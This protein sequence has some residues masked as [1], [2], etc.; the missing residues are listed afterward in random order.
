MDRILESAKSKSQIFIYT[1][2][3]KSEMKKKLFLLLFIASGFFLYGQ[4]QVSFEYLKDRFGKLDINYYLETEFGKIPVNSNKDIEV[5]AAESEM[6]LVIEMSNLRMGYDRDSKLLKKPRD[7]ENFFMQILK[8]PENITHE[9][10]GIKLIDISNEGRLADQKSEKINKNLE[11]RYSIKN[12]TAVSIQQSIYIKIFANAYED[13]IQIRPTER[14]G[15]TVGK[16]LL[17]KPN[18]KYVERQKAQ[19]VFSNVLDS[20]LSMEARKNYYD[21]FMEHFRAVDDSWT[22]NLEAWHAEVTGGNLL[23]NPE[24]ILFSQIKR[25]YGLGNKSLTYELCRKY[26]ER[27]ITDPEVIT[28]RHLP[29]VLYYGILSAENNQN[30]QQNEWLDRLQNLFPDFS[31]MD[32]IPTQTIA[33]SK[34]RNSYYPVQTQLELDSTIPDTTMIK[35]SLSLIDTTVAEDIESLNF[36]SFVEEDEGN[37]I[38][39]DND[40]EITLQ[41]NGISSTY[42]VNFYEQKTKKLQA[43]PSFKGEEKRMDLNDLNLPNGEYRVR[44]NNRNGVQLDERIL[45]FRSRKLSPEL[46]YIL[47]LSSILLIY[48]TYRKYFAL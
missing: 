17:I 18:P 45:S 7:S 5:T 2:A 39:H 37:I 35:D 42:I 43:N 9:G 20:T 48:W 26:D 8:S 29:D 12:T 16:T 46:R 36:I 44:L 14:G 1:K 15:K 11:I 19:E 23:D 10:K 32:E 4:Q 22:R 31:K 40:H 27:M 30:K 21:V 3:S 6:A 33:R 28:G 24:A 47:G 41:T 38:V 13:K 25:A 34:S